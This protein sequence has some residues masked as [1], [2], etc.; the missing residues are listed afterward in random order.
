MG[1]TQAQIAK[2]AGVS[3]GTVDR[4]IN[5]RG[6]VDPAV[7]AKIRQIAEELGYERNRAGSML[8][9]A[10]RTW[11]LGVI[12]Q[13]AETPF[14]Q[15]V[16][17]ELHKAEQK[18]RKMNVSLTILEREHFQLEQQLK[19]LDDLEQ[20]KMDGIA[21]M[22]VED[23]QIL[24][25]IDALWAN[26]IP[27]VTF[28]TDTP[29][30]RRLCYVGQDNYLS[31][32][33]CAGLMN[34]LLG[35]QGKVLMLSGHFSSFSHRRRIDGFQSEVHSLYPG[36]TL[37]PLERGNDDRQICYDCVHRVLNEHNDVRGIYLA[38][39]GQAGVCDCLR[40]LGRQE[41]VH[42]ICHDLL[43]DTLRG[44]RDGTIDFVIDQNASMQAIR[45]LEIL[46]E[47]LLS[48]EKP[49][50]EQLLMPIDIRTMYNI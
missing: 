43:P 41:K 7:E 44:L 30:S 16:L 13:S 31:G 24:E 5:R 14:I 2:L 40:D 48:G 15:L 29:G 42:F 3:R 28:N 1:V 22:P 33:A 9:R 37:L 36:L 19:D 35:G 11:Q 12:V 32:R 45:P 49:G 47:Y 25:R 6:H 18:L 46:T 26:N 10:Q 23:E 20:A 21:L 27:V 4:V 8:V 34:M 39:N 50:E 17:E 38:A